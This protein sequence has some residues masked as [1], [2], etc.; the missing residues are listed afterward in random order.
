MSPAA[1]AMREAL[2][3]VDFK[4]PS[5]PIVNNVQARAITDPDQLRADLVAQVT[6]RVRWRESVEWMHGNGIERL[7]ELGC[8]KVLTGMARRIVREL[9]GS[10]LNTPEG[11]ENFAK[12]LKG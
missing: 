11:L 1:D 8:G 3:D 9:K 5:V 6:G 7:A 12:E 4:S 10:A 2:A